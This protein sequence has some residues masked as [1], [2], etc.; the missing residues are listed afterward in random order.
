MRALQAK[1]KAQSPAQ[2]WMLFLGP[3]LS[4]LLCV[5]PKPCPAKVTVTLPHLH[6][7]ICVC[8]IISLITDQVLIPLLEKINDLRFILWVKLFPM[9]WMQCNQDCT[10]AP[11]RNCY[12]QEFSSSRQSWIILCHVWGLWLTGL[13]TKTQKTQQPLLDWNTLLLT[14]TNTVSHGRKKKGP[15][16]NAKSP[17]VNHLV[18]Q[19]GAAAKTGS[20]KTPKTPWG[21]LTASDQ[22]YGWWELY[23]T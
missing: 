15:P 2:L 12:F 18:L 23:S 14:Q 17:W 20:S 6:S 11:H 5:L 4:V 21:L 9:K 7:E 19:V 10:P 16:W 13:Q 1:P 8:S 3:A 22:G